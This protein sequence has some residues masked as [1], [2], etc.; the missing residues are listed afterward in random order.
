MKLKIKEEN[1]IWRIIQCT[2]EHGF[3]V[4]HLGINKLH[5][6]GGRGRRVAEKKKT[7]QRRKFEVREFRFFIARKKGQ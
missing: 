2:E 1:G 5:A 7:L 3:S 6:L 4:V